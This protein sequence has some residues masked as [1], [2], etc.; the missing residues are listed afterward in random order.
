MGSINKR[1]IID[2]R[3]SCKH[4]L[5]I[6]KFFPGALVPINGIPILESFIK[7]N[8][9]GKELFLLINPYFKKHFQDWQEVSGIDAKFVFKIKSDM[10]VDIR[11]KKTDYINFKGFKSLKDY[12]KTFTKEK[13]EYLKC[14]GLK[15]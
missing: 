12:E 1:V 4:L 8:T 13:E 5:P 11:N 7:Q 10:M 3:N 6:V 15:S 2:T 14:I 9:T